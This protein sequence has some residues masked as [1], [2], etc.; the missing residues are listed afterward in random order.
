MTGT[1]M[2]S[3]TVA[4]LLAYCD[5]LQDKGYQGAGAIEAWKTA[6]KKVFE[7]VEPDKYESISLD[8]LDLDDYVS[9][10]Q[11]LAGSSYKAETIGVY[12]RRVKNAI[13]AH[14]Y[15]LSNGRPPSFRKGSPRPKQDGEPEAAPRAKAAK[16]SRKPERPAAGL[17]GD[18]IEFPFPLRNGQIA[19]LRLPARLHKTDADR[20]STFLRTLQFEEQGQIPERTGEAITA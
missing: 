15:Y 1:D 10:F 11:T 7:T 9:R 19:E 12:A 14:D 20:L 13:E 2:N 4:G 6:V 18:L 16:A 5:W 8:G 17:T 3:R